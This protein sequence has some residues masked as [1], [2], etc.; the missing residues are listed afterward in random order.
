MARTHSR[1]SD[2]NRSQKNNGGS[3]EAA[4]LM[5]ETTA[6]TADEL[7]G[8]AQRMQEGTREFVAMGERAFETWMQSSNELMRRMLE[9]NMELAN[10]SREQLDDGI[11]A[12]R[13]LSQCRTVGD[14]YGVQI[15]LMRTS[16]EKS[17]RHASTIF[18]LTAGAMAGGMQRLRQ[19]GEETAREHRA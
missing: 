18:N 15:G 1:H 6:R 14:A 5:E 4:D 19:A 11:N 7:A 12:A 16:M 3:N 9:L 8:Q 17:L 13:S 2:N 10:W